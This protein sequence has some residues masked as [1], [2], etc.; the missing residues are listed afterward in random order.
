[1]NFLLQGCIRPLFSR[2]RPSTVTET[3]R[4]AIESSKPLKR[5]DVEAEKRDKPWKYREVYA[6]TVLVWVVEHA[7]VLLPHCLRLRAKYGVYANVIQA[8][9]VA[10]NWNLFIPPL[11]TL[12]DDPTTSIRARGLM[13]LSV[14]LP[15]LPSNLLAQTGLGPV[16][17]DAIL[18]TLL[19]LPSITPE[20]ESLQL[21]TPAYKALEVLAVARFGDDE[22]EK[23]EKMKFFDCILRK[24]ILM[25][26]FHAQEIPAIVEVLM[27]ELSVIIS[28]MGIYSVKHLKV[29]L[30]RALIP[31]LSY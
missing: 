15:K 9:I 13:I 24:G 31:V 30:H 7:S 26:Y 18:P 19:F 5:F 25:G 16:F 1:M 21:L 20:E 4:K 11:L 2:S 29:R 10:K 27:V 22:K 14:F 28:N 12:I 6:V 8:E 3:G 17:E 23:R